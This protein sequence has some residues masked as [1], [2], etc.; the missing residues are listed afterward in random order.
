MTECGR[1]ENSL[2][3]TPIPYKSISYGT[4]YHIEL[5]CLGGFGSL[6]V[7]TK[8]A[9]VLKTCNSV[10]DVDDLRPLVVFDSN[11]ERV[12]EPCLARVAEILQ[13]HAMVTPSAMIEAARRG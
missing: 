5:A 12:K 2:G 1:L 10:M 3:S 8:C 4:E 7:Q 13:D 11:L 9:T 6:F